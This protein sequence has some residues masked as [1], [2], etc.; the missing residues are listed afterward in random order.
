MQILEPQQFASWDDPVAMLFACHSRVKKFCHQLQILPDYVAKNGYNQAVNNDVQQIIQYFTQAAP[1]HHDDEE[2]DFFPA[3]VNY[4]PQAQKDI[5]ELERQHVIL[6]QNW[7][8][9]CVQLQELLREQR[10]NVER[11]LIKQFVA[12]YDVHIAIEEALFKLGRKHIPAP[13]LQAMGKIMA[14]RRQA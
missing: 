13:E 11:E 5:D 1:L 4:A 14:A 10:A 2:K 3:L 8:N 12:G 7:A 9:L 6:H